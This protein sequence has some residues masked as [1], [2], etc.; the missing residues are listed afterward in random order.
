MIFMKIEEC[1]LCG[2]IAKPHGYKGEVTLVL[3]VDNPAAYSDLD[4]FFVL[5]QGSLVPYFVEEIRLQ[6]DKA[7]VKLEDVAT[8]EAAQALVGNQV[9]LPMNNL[10]ELE[11]GQFYY[12]DI[13]GYRV[14]D[15]TAGELGEVTNV[16]EFP[17]QDL[18]AMNYQEQEVL[19][20]VID[21]IVLKADH[22]K[23]QLMVNLPEGLLDIYT[24]DAGTPDDQSDD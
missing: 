9:Y 14:V 10:P 20:P 23:K 6:E 21:E 1:F 11:E 15:T 18:I 4:S 16:Y 22:T 3:D 19:I 12:H 24:M 13:I 5:I 7:I 2:Y 17:H 8:Q